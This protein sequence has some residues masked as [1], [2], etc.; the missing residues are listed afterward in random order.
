MSIFSN[1][2]NKIFHHDSAP[3]STGT[4]T[5]A[6][7]AAAPA[8]GAAAAPTTSTAAS[9]PAQPAAQAAA[10][11]QEVDVEA[12]LTKMQANHGEQLNWRTSIVDLMKLLGLDSS[13]SARKELAAELHYSGNTE[14]SAAMNIWLHKQVMQKLAENG[15]KVP[16][17]LK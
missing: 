5:A 4:G 13:L 9:T 11:M 12:V 10:P 15:G 7:Q 14:D 6:G 16:D 1:I 17:E 3:A 8:G 2:L